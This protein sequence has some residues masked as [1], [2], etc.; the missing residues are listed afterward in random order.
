VKYRNGTLGL[1]KAFKILGYNPYHF[2]TCFEKDLPDLLLMT[3]AIEA[4]YH[5][6]GKPYGPEE[7]DKWFRDYDVPPSNPNVY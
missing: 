7:F 6:I 4:K 2:K 1:Y 5:N 3:E